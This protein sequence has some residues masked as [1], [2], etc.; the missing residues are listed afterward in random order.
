[1]GNSCCELMRGRDKEV[2]RARDKEVKRKE[3]KSQ[4]KSGR[5]VPKERRRRR[6]GRT[7]FL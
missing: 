3:N 4:K 6:G 1:M 5:A 7:F 2:R